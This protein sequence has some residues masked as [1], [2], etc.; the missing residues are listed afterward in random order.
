MSQN[1]SA[2]VEITGW[3]SVALASLGIDAKACQALFVPGRVELLGKHTDYAGGRSLLCATD[4]GIGFVFA[5]RKD[6]MIRVIR[7]DTNETIEFPIAADLAPK[8][9]HWTNY[10]M[11]VA[12]RVARNFLQPLIGVDIAIASNLPQAAG[13]SSSSAVIVGMFLTISYAN[14]LDERREYR[15]SIATREELAA[16]LGCVEN[17]Q[18]FKNLKGDRGVGTAGGSED[19]A[20]ILCCEPGC[21]TQFA[22]FPIR[23]EGSVK[24]PEEYAL[25]VACSGVIS[26]KTGTAMG[27]FN[28]LAMLSARILQSWHQATARSDASIAE[29]LESSTEAP[30][31]MFD[32]VRDDESMRRRLEQFIAERDRIIPTVH[33][34]MNQGR[35]SEIGPL[36]DESQ[37]LAEHNLKNQVPQTIE[38]AKSAR[39]LGA[40][41]ASSFGAG[42]GGSVWALVH[43]NDSDEFLRK[44]SKVYQEKFTDT[45]EFFLTRPSAPARLL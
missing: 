41:A 45:G 26:H 15:E 20:A 19:H 4:R 43:R 6:A 37:R 13:L 11:T 8:T 34:L 9:A 14:R 23:S 22:F 25:L 38:L 44:W 18:G 16:Y 30:E 42:F 36:V 32:I 28:R 3:A 12:R 2:A 39:E 35:W 5:P 33:A 7:A 24:L 17:G 1:L 27:Q 40:L 31:R 21:F 29:A 10:P